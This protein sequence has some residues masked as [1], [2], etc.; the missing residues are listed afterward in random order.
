ME[1]V[2]IIDLNEDDSNKIFIQTGKEAFS[3]FNKTL[4]EEA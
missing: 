2:K 3:V 1:E 4:L